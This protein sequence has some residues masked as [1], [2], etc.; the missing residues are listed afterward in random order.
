VLRRVLRSIGLACTGLLACG[1]T[2]E[3]T[4]RAASIEPFVGERN[5]P[6]RIVTLSPQASGFVAAIGAQHLLVGVDAESQRHLPALAELPTVAWADAADLDPDL[7][8]V[9]AAPA[10]GDPVAA[11]L[12]NLGARWIEFAPHSLEEVWELS[13]SVGA[14][15]VGAAEALR[16]ETEMARPLAKIGGASFGQPRPRVVAVVGLDPLE[17]AGGHSFETDLIEIAGGSSLTHGG[18]EPRLRVTLDE[19]AQYGAD[20]V[21]VVS[22]SELAPSEQQAAHDRLPPGVRLA[23]FP[24]DRDSF[25]LRDPTEQAQQLRAVIEPLSREL[26]ERRGSEP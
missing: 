21:L 13:R 12:R 11:R 1:P 25:W 5:G 22:A 8:L 23:F 3:T 19:L 16:F 26:A 20:L 4:P 15:L 14:E 7:V 17:L 18:S 9:P 6:L 2:S 24:L 10:A